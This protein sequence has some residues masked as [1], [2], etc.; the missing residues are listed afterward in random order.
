MLFKKDEILILTFGEYSDY[1][2]Q[3]VLRV[4]KDFESRDL[5]KQMREQKGVLRTALNAQDVM[6]GKVLG[7]GEFSDMFEAW[8]INESG[9]V[10]ELEHRE[11]HAQ[12][13]SQLTDDVGGEGL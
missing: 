1:G 2:F 11:L 13:Y 6:G 10:T 9:L 5:A 8:F 4:A 7:Y 3:A 12:T